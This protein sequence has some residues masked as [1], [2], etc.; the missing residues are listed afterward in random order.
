MQK[1]NNGCVART[2]TPVVPVVMDTAIRFCPGKIIGG[3][4]IK[5][6]KWNSKKKRQ[7]QQTNKKEELRKQNKRVDPILSCP[8]NITANID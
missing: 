7:Q 4:W 1:W 6:P 3:V 8:K 5:K 2:A